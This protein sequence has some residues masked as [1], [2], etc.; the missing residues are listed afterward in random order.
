VEQAAGAGPYALA[1]VR[2][3]RLPGEDH[4]TGAGRV[5][6][7]QYRP[8]VA[9]V[10]DPGQD[11]DQPGRAGQRVGQRYVDRR[12]HRDEPLRRD[13]L[14]E[15]GQRVLVHDRDRA[16]GQVG[17]PRRRGGR[18]EQLRHRTGAHRLPYPLGS[19]DQ[20]AAG[21]LAVAPPVQAPG[22]DDPGRP[23]RERNH[24]GSEVA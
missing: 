1:V 15:P 6:G 17:V 21:L 4:G 10:A 7:A 13:G 16:G 23:S 22:G 20:E 11:R 2:V 5:G 9:R 14:G 19:F 8:R 18:G 12:A 3:D 24:P